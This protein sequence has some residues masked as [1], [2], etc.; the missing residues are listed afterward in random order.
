M[1]HQNSS[2]QDLYSLLNLT[3]DATDLE[4]KQSFKFLSRLFHPDKLGTINKDSSQSNEL[5]PIAI[6]TSNFQQIVYAYEVLS[7]AQKRIV[8]DLY[9]HEGLS[10][11]PSLTT[12]QLN[13]FSLF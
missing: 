11:V 10:N 9:G 5:T 7:D 13:K 6:V 3:Q 12:N 2:R 1:S 8:Y 4:I